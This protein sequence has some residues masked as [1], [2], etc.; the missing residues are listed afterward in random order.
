MRGWKSPLLDKAINRVKSH[1]WKRL[2]NAFTGTACYGLCYMTER[3]SRE[4]REGKST[5]QRDGEN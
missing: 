4:G 5:E 2:K 3:S 1:Y